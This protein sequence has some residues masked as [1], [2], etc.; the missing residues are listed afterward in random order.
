MT[1]R[2]ATRIIDKQMY[3]LGYTNAALAERV[4][5]TPGHLIRIKNFE[6]LPNASTTDRLA[7]ALMMPVGELRAL[8]FDAQEQKSEQQQKPA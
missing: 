8:I 3:V 6:I 1:N 2:E 5:I 7:T 4:G